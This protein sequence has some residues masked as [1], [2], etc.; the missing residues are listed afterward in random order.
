MALAT[1]NRV[2][3]AYI[4]E[5]S[6]GATPATPQMILLP[7]QSMSL[8][9][10]KDV[11]SDPTI[12]SDRMERYERH[13][14]YKVS[15]N[16]VSSLQHAQ[17][18]DFIEAAMGGTWTTNVVKV[19]TQNRSFTV[20]QGFLDIAQYRVFTGVRVNQWDLTV[21]P[22]AVVQSTF[23]LIG[24]GMTTSSTALDVTPTG[25]LTKQPMV[26]IG[27]S[28]TVGGTGVKATA[29]S[30]QLTNNMVAQYG[31]GSS[32]ALDVSQHESQ[33]TGSMTFYFENLI[34]Y[35]RFLNETTAPISVALTDGTNTLTVSIP[36]AKFNTGALP[37]SGSNADIFVTMSYKALYDS[38]SQTTVSV[39]RS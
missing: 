13:G 22:N 26:H 4:P 8:D 15:G 14:N 30:M 37:V 6:F 10:A 38:A 20:E 9:L 5:V 29:F 33:C 31:I 12:I 17:W 19:G 7:M 16:I 34:A 3:L 27:A 18:D 2:Q 28:I 32:A 11:I 25:V 1:S 24:S 35:N 23:G 21:S 36:N 39:T